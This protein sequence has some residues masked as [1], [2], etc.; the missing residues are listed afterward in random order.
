M[1]II[2]TIAA[3]RQKI[4]AARFAAKF[5][6]LVPTMG[7]L[8]AGHGSLISRAVEECDLVVVSIFVNPT[9]FGPGE[10]LGRYPRNLEQD[11]NYCQKLGAHLI[12]APMNEEMYPQEQY[13]WVEVEKLTKGLCGL[14]RP[15]HFRGVATVCLKLF[16]IVQPDF[17]YFGQKDAQQAAVIERMVRDLNLPLEIRVSPIIRDKDG[18]ALSSRNQYL[19]K[20]ERK[21]ALCLYRSL[22]KCRD[23]VA[24]GLQNTTAICREMEVFFQQP[25]VTLEYIEIVDPNTLEKLSE[26]KTEALIAVAARVGTTRLIDNLRINLQCP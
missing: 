6:G 11:R 22:E 3:M 24:G 14:H 10:D 23:L 21:K 12:F 16:N 4:K 2:T 9:Q 5:I 26:I 8:H 7:A 20:E 13:A 15:G 1:E 17:A 18:L 19:S 25:G